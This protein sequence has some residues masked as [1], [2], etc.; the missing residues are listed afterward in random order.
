[1]KI[2]TVNDDGV[3]AEGNIFL[4]EKLAE[5]NEVLTVAPHQE[6]SSCG[7]AITLGEPVRLN[8]LD[9]K[10]Y[11]CTGYPAD[12]V[13][14]ALGNFYADQR[15]DLVISGINIGA[16]LG[17][18]RF[19]S[20]TI[21]AAREASF[22]DIPSIAVSLVLNSND[23]IKHF[24][25]AAHYVSE[26]VAK[27]IHKYIPKMCVLNINVPNVSVNHVKGSC[28]T[29]TGY[30]KYSEEIIKRTDGRGRTYF[31]VGGTYD[32]HEDIPGSDC[33]AVSDGYIA[34]TLQEL[35]GRDVDLTNVLEEIKAII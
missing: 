28:L 3:H 6:R 32:G 10:T 17:Q 31:W 2:L 1:M 5:K 20:G 15:P 27:G 24:E 29:T 25:T 8:Q 19:Y 4:R 34:V 16:N 35:S 18:D 9:D 33:N 7:H 14:V 12:C 21:A 30:Q 22:R 11:S 13:L 23:H 26:L